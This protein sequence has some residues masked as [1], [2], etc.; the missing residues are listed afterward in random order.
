MPTL[1]D[2]VRL[3]HARRDDEHPG[4]RLRPPRREF[5]PSERDARTEQRMSTAIERGRRRRVRADGLGHRRGVRP[6]RGPCDVVV[7]EIDAAA[8]E[9]GLRPASAPRST[10]AGAPASSTRPNATSA[11]PHLR[12]RPTSPSSPIA[13]SSS[14]PSPRTSRLRSTCSPRS[15]GRHRPVGI[16][17]SN[18]SSIPIMK[19]GIATSGPSRSSA[20]TSSTRS[21]CSSLVELVTTLMTGPTRPIGP[22]RSPRTRCTSA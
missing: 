8:A 12:S 6:G 1:I 22:R 16:L 21:R 19:L 13:S 5:P 14:R 15:T 17:A 3:R 4:R 18:T 20:S 9:A 10:A 2:T 11:R 7:R